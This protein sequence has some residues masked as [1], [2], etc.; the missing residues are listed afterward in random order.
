MMKGV[1]V[2]IGTSGRGDGDS[3]GGDSSDIVV[4][5]DVGILRAPNGL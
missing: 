1:E 3:G 5:G 4:D 2:G